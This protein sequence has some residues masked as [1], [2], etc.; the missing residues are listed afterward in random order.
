VGAGEMGEAAVRHLAAN[1]ANL[2]RVTNRSP[3]AA[4]KLSERFQ[5]EAVPFENLARWVAQSDIVITSTGSQEILISHTMAHAAHA[6]RGHEPMV[7]IDISVPRNVDP[8]VA[9]IDNISCYDVDDLGAVVE[10]N[11]TERRLAA[12]RAEKIVEEEA[13]AFCARVKSHELGPVVS[14]LQDRI[15]DIC[16]TELRR[17]VNRNGPRD[18]HEIQELEWMVTRI[19]NKIVHPMVMQL[20]SSHH[21]PKHREVYLDT[22]RRFFGL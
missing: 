11:F 4:Q 17:F 1:G 14:Q 15:A 6:E 16:K 21:N 2:I 7:F 20:R 13:E 9:S 12:A 18:E 10:A 5:G 8:A 3:E 22:I 19:A